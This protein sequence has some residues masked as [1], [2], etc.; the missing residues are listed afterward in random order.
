MF[1][2]NIIMLVCGSS[3]M[4]L[5]PL[6]DSGSHSGS[7]SVDT[8]GAPVTFIFLRG[9]RVVVVVAVAVAVVAAASA[10]RNDADPPLDGYDDT[11]MYSTGVPEWDAD[12]CNGG[13]FFSLILRE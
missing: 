3:S 11:I 9:F 8:G 13:T 4:I 10:L 6:G 2:L 7:I 12:V 1:G 5:L